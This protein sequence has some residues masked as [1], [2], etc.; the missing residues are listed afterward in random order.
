MTNLKPE[1][2]TTQPRQKAPTGSK[3]DDI[4]SYPEDLMGPEPLSR[5]RPPSPSPLPSG[6]ALVKLLTGTLKIPAQ[7]F[8]GQPDEADVDKIMEFCSSLDLDG[9]RRELARSKADIHCALGNV[10]LLVEAVQNKVN[11]E[12][13]LAAQREALLD[14]F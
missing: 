1:N 3:L 4:G 8:N 6:D 10:R 11:K 14:S 5:H 12:R 7:N 13:A 2:P 9:C